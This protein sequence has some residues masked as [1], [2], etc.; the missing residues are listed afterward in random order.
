M[1]DLP[2]WR[3]AL[4]L[5]CAFMI[6]MAKTGAPGVGTMIAPL[7]VMTVGDARYAAA[8]AV[9][10]LSTA[11]IFAVSYWR[12][13]AQAMKLFSMIPWVAAGMIGGAVALTWSEP[14]LRKTI[15]FIVVS[16]VVIYLWRKTRPA[17]QVPGRAPFYGVATGFAS[18]VA[19]AAGPV[20]N[21]YLISQRLP[22]EQFV[23]TGAWFFLVVN[24]AKMPIYAWHNLFSRQSLLFDLCMVPAVL[25][26]ALAGLWILRRIPQQLFDFLVIALTAVS[27]IFLFR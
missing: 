25:G 10:I 24:F 11:D 14:V 22:K 15:G 26:G 9:P 5:F 17:S 21:M 3:W 16:M 13:H 1:P 7:V 18:T 23:A 6:G 8:W 12:R 19:N 2:P 27:T 20:M 4:G